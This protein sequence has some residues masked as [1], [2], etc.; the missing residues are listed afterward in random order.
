MSHPVT[1]GR[2]WLSLSVVSPGLSKNKGLL[3]KKDLL[4]GAVK[5]K[6]VSPGPGLQTLGRSVDRVHTRG[7]KNPEP[8]DPDLTEP[9]T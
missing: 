1:T 8:S 4:V 9:E 2:V 3:D 5:G 7:R 6:G